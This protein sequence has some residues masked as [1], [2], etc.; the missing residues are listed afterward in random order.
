[1]WTFLRQIN[2]EGTTIILTTHYLEEAESLCRTIGIIDGGRVIED[3]SMR[4]LLDT[5]H[6]KTFVLYL[7]NAVARLPPLPGYD[8][9]QVDGTTIEVSISKEENLNQVSRRCRDMASK[10]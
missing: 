5:L 1:M 3:T 7:R 2:V 10:C 4:R 8:A 9:K 6:L